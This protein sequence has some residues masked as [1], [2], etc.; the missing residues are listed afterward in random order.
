MS[1]QL[2]CLFV[3]VVVI[4]V[5]YRKL[6]EYWVGQSQMNLKFG[7]VFASDMETDPKSELSSGYIMVQ[8]SPLLWSN[9]APLSGPI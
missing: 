5:S 1:K 2:V 6:G 3:V 9:L 8:S 4:Y 7:Y